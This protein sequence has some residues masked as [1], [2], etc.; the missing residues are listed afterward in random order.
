MKK[1]LLALTAVVL[2]FGACKKTDDNN[3]NNT[4]IT[5][6][7]EQWALAI[8]YTATWC[9]YCGSW[10][11]PLIKETGA[12]PR[13]VAITPHASNDPMYNATFYSQF[14]AERATGGG[15]PS[16]WV[17]DTK[18]G[19]GDT[20]SAAQTATSLMPSAAL[21]MEATRNGAVYNVKVKAEWYTAGTGEYYL[22]VFLLESGIDGSASAGQ[23]KQ[24]GTSDPAYTH[25][26]VFRT[27]ATSSLYGDM[28]A[29]S[30]AAAYTVEK[31]YAINILPD[32][33]K[34]VYPVAI[35]WKYD[36]TS[37]KPNYK[38]VNAIKL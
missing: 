37:A 35:L 28:I 20:K 6:K 19:Q 11:A 26:F 22:S 5:V 32:W 2:L 4:G 27:C 16:F 3:N 25:S 17:N 34:T 15:I 18:T 21:G 8:N 13:V 10:G 38:F 12:L 1:I 14:N 24:S 36:P 9:G 23:Y 29:S 33:Q 7:K 30:P 31:E